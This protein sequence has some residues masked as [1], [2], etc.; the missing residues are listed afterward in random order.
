[1][2]SARAYYRFSLG[3][4]AAG[5]LT[6]ILAL[7]AVPQ[8]ITADLPTSGELA[9]ACRL[10]LAASLPAILVTVLASIGVAAGVCAL[11]SL[12]RHCRAQRRLEQRLNVRR[13]IRVGGVTAHVFG[14][15]RPHAFCAGLLRPRIYLSTGALSVLSWTELNA[16]V[17][18][19]AHHV[20]Q[21]DPLRI[22]LARV[23]RDALFFLPIMRHVADRY[24]AL[25]EMAADD[26]AVRYCGDRRA[27]ASAMLIFEERAPS[28]A[29]GIAPERVDHL[30]GEPARWQLSL[31]LLAAGIATLAA[32][33]LLGVATALAVPAD[34]IP[35]GVMLGQACMFAMIAAPVIAGATL[36]LTVSR[37]RAPSAS[38]IRRFLGRARPITDRCAASP[39]FI[40]RASS[41]RARRHRLRAGQRDY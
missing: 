10:A 41:S 1:M 7:A 20:A 24:C 32:V 25:A 23:L 3:L 22:L 6:L 17:A 12:D 38:L 2:A 8:A 18:H 16:V 9:G 35:V 15:T 5:V 21:R 11:R 31:S 14:D 29:V 13:H 30:L 4:G 34:G 36:I 37:A 40:P 33:G 19:E 26:A 28:G 27:L 39:R